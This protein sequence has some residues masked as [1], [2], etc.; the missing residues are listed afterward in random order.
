VDFHFLDPGE[1][2]GE[3]AAAGFA[4]EARLDREPV[5]GA[6]APSRRCYVLARRTPIP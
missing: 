1:V 5:K 2:T 4:I 6:E 3:L